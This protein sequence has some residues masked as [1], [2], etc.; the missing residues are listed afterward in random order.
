MAGWDIC[1]AD[2]HHNFRFRSLR[3]LARNGYARRCPMLAHSR[4]HVF[5]VRLQPIATRQSATSRSPVVTA[6]CNGGALRSEVKRLKRRVTPLPRLGP[7]AF[8]Q[9]GQLHRVSGNVRPAIGGRQHLLPMR[10]RDEFRGPQGLLRAGTVR[11]RR[12]P[13]LDRPGGARTTGASARRWH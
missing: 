2:R 10:R 12:E 4:A 1:I 9:R 3:R 7:R 11:P 6:V 5:R 13:T 8:V